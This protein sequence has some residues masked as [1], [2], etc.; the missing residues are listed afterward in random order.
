MART[1]G[2]V[3]LTCLLGLAVGASVAQ[4]DHL[5]VR[6]PYAMDKGELEAAYWLDAFLNTPVAT[7]AGA[8][9]RQHLLRHTAELAYG[10][11]DRWWVEVY[12]DFEQ[13]TKGG[14]EQTTFV[15]HRY[16]TVYRFLDRH[17]FWPAAAFYVEY[18]IPQ[19]RFE[20][21]DEVEWKLLLESRIKDFMVRLNPVWEREFN[22]AS[23]VRFGYENGWYWFAS[24]AVRLG[25]EGFGTFGPIGSFPTTN[26]QSHS[27][28]PAVKFKIGPVGWD[29]GMQFG[30]TDVSDYVVFKSILDFSF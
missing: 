21:N 14:S 8:F 3:I 5:K 13:P 9:P 24:S 27:W 26:A 28:G 11:T 10:I 23:R 29:M 30:W 6:N 19:R 25:V 18:K 22:D 7:S 16:E 1:V 2:I 17:D 15:R 12:A 20:H 4:A